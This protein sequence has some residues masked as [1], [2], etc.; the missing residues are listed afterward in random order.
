M[1]S[2]SGRILFVHARL[3]F[4]PRHHKNYVYVYI[5]IYV[6][7]YMY[8]CVYIYSACTILVAWRSNIFLKHT[9]K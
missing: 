9:D 1:I 4:E 5:S 7:I 8:I 3:W 2:N 6:C